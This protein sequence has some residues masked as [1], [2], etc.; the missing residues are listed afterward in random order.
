[1]LG[2]SPNYPSKDRSLRSPRL[3]ALIIREYSG[4]FDEEFGM[5]KFFIFCRLSEWNFYFNNNLTFQIVIKSK[6][7]RCLKTV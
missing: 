4:V 2:Y 1:M 3:G 7:N 5:H 6:S